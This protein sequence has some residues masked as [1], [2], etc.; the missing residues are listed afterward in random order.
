MALQNSDVGLRNRLPDREIT[1]RRE[2][3]IRILV[4]VATRHGLKIRMIHKR[5]RLT[6]VA[7]ESLTV[8]DSQTSMRR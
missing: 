5:R 8:E 2:R 4:R 1:I 3:T 7:I 6:N